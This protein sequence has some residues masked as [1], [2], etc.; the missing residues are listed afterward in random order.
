[1]KL[2]NAPSGNGAVPVPPKE[3]VAHIVELLRECLE[4]ISARHAVYFAEHGEHPLAI[5]ISQ[6]VASPPQ[7]GSGGHVWVP[8]FSAKFK[9]TAIPAPCSRPG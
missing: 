9:A 4:L 8:P 6:D 2:R 3:L 5:V 1:M 7:G